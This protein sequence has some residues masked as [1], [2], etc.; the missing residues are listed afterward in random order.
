MADA[1]PLFD[2]CQV[3]YGGRMTR[4]VRIDCGK[5][6]K[7]QKVPLNQLAHGQKDDQTNRI[8]GRKFEQSGWLIGKRIKDHRCP[9]CAAAERPQ[10]KLHVVEAMND[11]P[12]PSR[13]LTKED[14]RI[15]FS[16]LNEVYVDE[17]TGYS[18][19]WSDA[20]VA[21]NLGVPNE[22][23]KHIREENFGPLGV[24]P[25]IAA[26]ITEA[27]LIREQVKEKTNEASKI[28]SEIDK[29]KAAAQAFTG[30]I[31]RLASRTEVIE[32][33]IVQLEKEL[34]GGK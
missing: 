32:K 13:Q 6:G 1:A 3:D 4:G 23:V 14:R 5:C 33:K 27:R 31:Q 7:V 24:N 30:D 20:N 16:K 21:A 11:K 15:I 10:P 18:E 12:Q 28:V 25:E 22:W 34:R 9:E 2:P 8:A 26:L 17:S 19:T 29:A